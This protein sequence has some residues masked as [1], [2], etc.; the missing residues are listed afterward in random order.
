MAGTGRGS[1]GRKGTGETGVGEVEG[2]GR[3][4]GRG[5]GEKGVGEV[6]D[7]GLE[8]EEDDWWTMEGYQLRKM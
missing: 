5:E 4:Q 1:G 8:V 7:G 2:G 3:G 6:E